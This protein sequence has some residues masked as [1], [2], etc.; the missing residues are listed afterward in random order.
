[1]VST[2]QIP[3]PSLATLATVTRQFSRPPLVRF[4]WP[5]TAQER[6][7]PSPEAGTPCEKAAGQQPCPYMIVPKHLPGY[8]S[9][10]RTSWG[11]PHVSLLGTASTAADA[12]RS[13]CVRFGGSSGWPRERRPLV[14]TGSLA[15]RK[16]K[17]R[18][19]RCPFAP[20]TSVNARPVTASAATPRTEAETVL[21]LKNR[22]PRK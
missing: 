12:L 9:R 2:G 3:R 4:S 15:H 11:T 7:S 14:T 16:T 17:P 20:R 6:R 22:F 1:M 13:E 8:D 18:S 19:T 10:A 21:R 5:L